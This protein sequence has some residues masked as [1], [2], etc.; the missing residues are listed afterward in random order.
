MNKTSKI[1]KKYK[2]KENYEMRQINKAKKK[3]WIN[4]KVPK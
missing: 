4:K 3:S 2:L 1:I